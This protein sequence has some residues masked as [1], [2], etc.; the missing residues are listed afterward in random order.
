MMM[1]KLSRAY[2]HSGVSRQT[3]LATGVIVFILLIII[4]GH[5]QQSSTQ[6]RLSS[7]SSSSSGG[8][9]FG[10]V[11]EN[12]LNLVTWNVAAV[13]NNPFEYWIT[14]EDPEY[15]R[16]MKNVSDMIE[17]PGAN[18]ITV[19][20]VISDAIMLDLFYE[21]EKIGW[22]GV[23]ETKYRWEHEYR[24]RKI[25]SEFIKDGMLGKKRLAS[26][27]DRVTN[28]ITLYVIYITL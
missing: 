8:T 5:F 28:T 4:F 15:N 18:D 12:L 13:N 9:I 11:D 16:M 24:D 25:I 2:Q 21:L 6:S 23:N 3:K 19:K 14:S 7:S 27:P 17:N 22:K 10:K 1:G 26:M 20:E